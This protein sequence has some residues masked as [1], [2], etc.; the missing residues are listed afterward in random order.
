MPL[1]Y[2]AHIPEVL[3]V[4]GWM[5]GLLFI[6]YVV[7]LLT[8]SVSHS[9]GLKK[10]AIAFAASLLPFGT[11]VLDKKILREEAKAE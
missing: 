4:M 10:S 3:K 1:K 9:W 6:L 7:L 2:A 11:F 8:V 5:H